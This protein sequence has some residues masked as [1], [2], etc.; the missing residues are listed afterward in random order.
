[1][2]EEVLESNLL[3]LRSLRLESDVLPF[4]QGET[5]FVSRLLPFYTDVLI[6]R[7][8]QSNHKNVCIA[9]AAAVDGHGGLSFV[10]KFPSLI[11]ASP[12]A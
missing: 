10:Q 5:E 4:W 3:L 12:L 8:I 9:H 6:A 11:Q 2:L 1:M 7:Q